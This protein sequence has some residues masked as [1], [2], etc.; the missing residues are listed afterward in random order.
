MKEVWTI[1]KMREDTH[2]YKIIS[3]NVL[4]TLIAENLLHDNAVIIVDLYNG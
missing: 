3:S 1:K 4:S 2:L